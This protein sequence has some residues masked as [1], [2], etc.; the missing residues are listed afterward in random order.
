MN[1]VIIRET[2][3]EMRAI[4]RKALRGNW[5]P[6]AIA[7]AIYYILMITAPLLVDELIP[8]ATLY[9]GVDE[10][11]GEEMTMPII[12]TLYTIIL[13]GPLTAGMASY[14]LYFFR[15]K[16]TR[17]GHLFDGF[18]YFLKSIV[19]TFLVGGLILLW[20]LLLVIPGIIAAFR[21]SQAFYIL[22]DHPE[23]SAGQCIRMSKAYMKGNKG[24]LFCLELSYLG[25]A[26]LAGI[27]AIPLVWFPLTGIAGVLADF[28]VSIPNFFFMAYNG[29]GCIVFYELVS[30][31][32]MARPR[33]TP[34]NEDGVG[35]V[36]TEPV[37]MGGIPTLVDVP[38][39]EETKSE[40][41]DEFNF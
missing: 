19:L 17:P 20:S 16:D 37:D 21:Y 25:W 28:V 41:K 38:V 32:L 26:L 7:M 9:G 13:T 6:V 24:K 34:I 12:S 10:L 3:S 23:Y 15:N 35:P 36:P 29:I 4:A 8:G 5:K 2:A 31:N 33:V 1:H 39:Q 14:C 11:T 40:N 22:A 18:E 27:A 30:G